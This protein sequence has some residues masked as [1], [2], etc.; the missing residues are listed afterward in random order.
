V[1]ALLFLA[2]SG[3]VAL[4]ADDVPKPM[5]G[6]SSVAFSADKDGNKKVIIHNFTYL[7][8]DSIYL[9]SGKDVKPMAFL[10]SQDQSSSVQMQSDTPP[11]SKI[12]ATVWGN[13]DGL[14]HT[15]L[16]T[17]ET[18]GNSG[19]IK[20]RF[21]EVKR[22]GFEDDFPGYAYFRLADGK[23]ALYSNTPLLTIY[24]PGDNAVMRYIGF[25]DQFEDNELTKA[26]S[27]KKI[28]GIAFAI[29]NRLSQSSELITWTLTRGCA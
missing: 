1:K 18:R 16:W 11:D 21:Y 3:L 17:L 27:A 2:L 6:T 10:I 24:P 29:V 4:A 12:K 23:Q 5:Q 7:F 14:P 20:D 8:E 22:D 28:A 19:A 15:Q 26:Q 9:E 25:R 13:A